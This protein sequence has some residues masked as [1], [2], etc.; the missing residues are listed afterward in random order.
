MNNTLE[1]RVIPILRRQIYRGQEEVAYPIQCWVRM[2]R[3]ECSPQLPDIT[4][5]GALVQASTLP[6]FGMWRQVDP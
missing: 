3:A 2:R 4:E 1:V 5:L 6:S